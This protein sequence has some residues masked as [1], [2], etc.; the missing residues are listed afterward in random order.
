MTFRAMLSLPLFLFLAVPAGRAQTHECREVMVPM[1]EAWR[2]S[3]CARMAASSASA[4]SGA[5]MATS[6]PSLAT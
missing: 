2:P 3:G 6:L 5:T 4:A 1:R